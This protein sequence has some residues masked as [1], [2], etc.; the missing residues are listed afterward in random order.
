M[1][2]SNSDLYQWVLLQLR[3]RLNEADEIFNRMNE[4]V[5]PGTVVMDLP[6]DEQKK[7]QELYRKYWEII[8]EAVNGVS[9]IY[10]GKIK[11]VPQ[12]SE[13]EVT[14]ENIIL[15]Q[16]QVKELEHIVEQL[17]KQPDYIEGE[18]VE[19]LNSP[20]L[21]PVRHSSK[22]NK[23]PNILVAGYTGCGKS[24]LIRTVIGNHD[25]S[26]NYEIQVRPDTVKFDYY[27]NEHIRIW[28]SRGLILGENE[29]EFLNGMQ[30]FIAERQDEPDVDDHIHL[31]WYLIQGN[32]ARV[33]D[34]DIKLIKEIMPVKNVIVVIS[35]SDITKPAQATAIRQALIEAG[36]PEKHIVQTADAEA[37]AAGCSELVAL[38]GAMLPEAYQG[39]FM[40]A[41]QIDRE[42]REELILQ[43]TDVA[44]KIIDEAVEEIRNL[45]IYTSGAVV[46]SM[47]IMAVELACLYGVRDHQIHERMADFLQEILNILPE[48]NA[49]STGI[50]AE[51]AGVWL[52]KNLS[53]Y[54]LARLKGGAEI[55]W[56]FNLDEFK[57]FYHIY[58]KGMSMKPNIL[59]CGKTGAG[60]TSLIQ[61]VTH[62]GVVPDSA[63][64]NG[65]PLTVGFQV[66]ETEAVNFIDAEGMEPGRQSVD[67]YADFISGELMQ[68][69]ETGEAEKI[70][71]NIWYCIDGSGSRIQE[72]DAQLIKNFS[73]KVI[74]VITKSEL[75]RKEELKSMMNT[76]LD[77]I[78]SERIAIVSAENKTGLKQLIAK[79]EQMSMTAIDQAQEEMEAFQNRWNSYYANMRRAWSE[80]VSEEADSYIK[81]AAGRAA[82]IAFIPLPLAD[83]TPLIANEIYM[84]YKLAGLY[85]I[86]TDN[87]VISMLLGCAGGSIAGKIGASML[88]FLKI[89]IAAAVTYGVGKTAKAYFESDMTLNEDDLRKEFLAAE[90]EA[91]NKK[92]DAEQE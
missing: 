72:A 31:I 34:C 86:A 14:R 55:E 60:K 61:A 30:Q 79:A 56:I 78:D 8:V 92:W 48:L 38:T 77:L 63:I 3:E 81:W 89:P 20:C 36:I 26:D 33:T 43:K 44:Q 13:T 49:E 39:A 27:E 67:E 85:G 42:A 74:L 35:K 51:I 54:A 66:Y 76:L 18:K 41:Q 22:F 70:I 57:H 21:P 2:N 17:L 25:N 59:V 80:C 53:S 58:M 71:H 7:I 90:R 83:V 10:C 47:Q 64:G 9:L 12:I 32:G 87:T 45:D 65:R 68:R 62:R 73:D 29:D 84:I 4:T 88:P 52:K 6:D 82:A 16:Q 40:M 69:L 11:P 5:L 50:L 23:K 37:G 75:M 1:K 28:D 91:K 19:V 24:S 46:Q 15:C